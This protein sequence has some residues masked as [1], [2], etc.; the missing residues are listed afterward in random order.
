MLCGSYSQCS[1]LSEAC[2]CGFPAH[3][4]F[5]YPNAVLANFQRLE[6]DRHGKRG[7]Q[8]SIRET[9]KKLD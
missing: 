1:G 7:N 2:E 3:S 5:L 4:Y 6:V 8:Y 9:I